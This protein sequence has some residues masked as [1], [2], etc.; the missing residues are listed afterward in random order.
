MTIRELLNAAGS[1]PVEGEVDVQVQ[2]LRERETKGGKPYFQLH[3][4]DATGVAS[5]NVWN[6]H[7]QW[8]SAVETLRPERALRLSG[9]WT[10][11][12]YGLDARGWTF[13]PLNEAEL[14]DFLAGDPATRAKQEADWAEIE[15]R[16]AALRD[17]RLRLLCGKFLEVHG[18][19]F[20]RAAAARKNHH[21]RRGGLVEHVAQ[22]MR[23]AVA[24]H[25]AYPALNLDLLIAAILFHDC[26]KLWENN[27]ARDGFA[28][29]HQLVGEMLGHI[30]LGLELI[31]S[32]WNDLDFSEWEEAVPDGVRVRLHLLH[33]VA[34]HHGTHE[35]GSPTLPKTP[36][37]IVLH[38]IDNMDAKLEM[39]KDAYETSNELAPG[40]YERKFPLPAN[41][42]KPLEEWQD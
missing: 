26:G 20:Q 12:D 32:L 30:P 8:E 10:Q 25:P 11:N 17:P 19:R 33:L 7:P 40:I 37:A 29:K 14:A 35:F 4:A 41:L 27:Y 15:E 1:E 6:N 9:A 18:E 21:A 38:H 28:Q 13:R 36:E 42:I 31:N 2:E 23:A 5:L 3:F 39:M 16:V 24:L 22:M 34:S